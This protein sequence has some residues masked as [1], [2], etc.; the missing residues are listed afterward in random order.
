MQNI[1]FLQITQAFPL[2]LNDPPLKLSSRRSW[3]E[4]RE[5]YAEILKGMVALKWQ[6]DVKL[7][8]K[9]THVIALHLMVK[10]SITTAIVLDNTCDQ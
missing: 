9:I 5:N 2:K 4:K 6:L 8:R 10:K 1:I 3:V 7:S